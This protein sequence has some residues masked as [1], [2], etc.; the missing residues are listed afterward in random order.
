MILKLILN[1]TEGLAGEVREYKSEHYA[2]ELIKNG[3]AIEVQAAPEIEKK[4]AVKTE[5]K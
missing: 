2:R 3:V 5:K 1:S 4:T